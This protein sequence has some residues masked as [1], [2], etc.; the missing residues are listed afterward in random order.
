MDR[1]LRALGKLDGIEPSPGFQWRVREAFLRAHPEFLER[2]HSESLTWWQAMRGSFGFVPAWAISIAAHVLL[3][4]LAAILIFVP[5]SPEEE[6]EDAAIRAKPRVPAVDTPRFAGSAPVGP[7]SRPERIGH[8]PERTPEAEE[9]GPDRTAPGV[10]SP[11]PHRRRTPSESR[12]EI[13]NWR[14]KIPRERRLLAFFEA[15]GNREAREAE[16]WHGAAEAVEAGLAWLARAQRTDGAWA[17]PTLRSEDGAEFSYSTGLTGLALL[18][19][20]A[21]GHSGRSGPYAATVRRG[22]DLLLSR[23]R[24]SGL[25]GFDRGN[26]MYD[27]AIAALALLE[28]SM[29]TRDEGLSAAAAAAVNFTVAAQNETGGWGYT[30]RSPNNVMLIVRGMG[31]AV[32]TR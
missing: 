1:V 16:G 24:V 6:M 17:G 29:M 20:L 27:H 8:V 2:P 28:A 10:V 31:V 11:A 19:F 26:Y 5:R 12:M 15:R 18:A 4:S 23:Q 25:I 21:E 22:L 14:V 3:I 30:S 7:P 32:I 13:E 9:Y